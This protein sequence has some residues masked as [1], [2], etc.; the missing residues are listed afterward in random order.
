MS[1]S[2][3]QIEASASPYIGPFMLPE[4]RNYDRADS[5]SEEIDVPVTSSEVCL[6]AAA[7]VCSDKRKE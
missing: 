1:V 4:S 3:F 2:D 5:L 6:K 7:S